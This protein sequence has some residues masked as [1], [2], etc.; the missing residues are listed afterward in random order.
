MPAGH[1]DISNA[2][3]AMPQIKWPAPLPAGWQEASPGQMRVAAFKIQEG[4][5]QADLGV[6]PL[7]G[8]MGSDL[9]SVNR[10]RGSVGLPAVTEEELSKLAEKVE[11][12]GQQADFYDQA[13]ENP[14]S[15]E[16]NR[17]QAAILRRQG[18]AWFFKLTGD[19]ELVARQKPA[20]LN[21]LKSLTFVDAPPRSGEGTL[22][23]SHPPIGGGAP[24]GSGSSATAQNKPAW[25]V[26]AGWKEVP[27]GQFLVAKFAI[28]G[29]GNEQAAVNVS[30]SA[31]AGGGLVGNVNRWR[32]QLGLGE[33][34]E[35]EITKLVSPLETG[36]VKASLVDMTGTDTRSGQKAR[37]IGAI[38]PRDGSTW[39]YKLMGSEQVV[40]LQ[41]NAF[42]EFVRSAKYQ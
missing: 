37:L 4:T 40:E 41:K 8:M 11:V 30:T 18:V 22:P 29:T 27:A 26:P 1:P 33:L 2:G 6:V 16:K 10:W 35:A 31:G 17:V 15:G 14:G 20:F 36:G 28:T 13:G 3:A 32:G 39:F 19:D 24:V 9:E 12:A 38:V 21:V 7:P 23:P 25:Q 42:S 34:T 5:K